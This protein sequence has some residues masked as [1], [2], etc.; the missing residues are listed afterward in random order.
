MFIYYS[1]VGVLSKINYG[2]E[3]E[4][5]QLI[6]SIVAFILSLYSF[7]AEIIKMSS[8]R[9]KYFTFW[10]GTILLSVASNVVLVIIDFLDTIEILD[11][12]GSVL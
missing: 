1:T 4:T 11:L 7:V 6:T 8:L 5:N 10:N 9:M 12:E 3:W 2:G